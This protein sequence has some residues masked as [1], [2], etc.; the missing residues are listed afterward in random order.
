MKANIKLALVGGIVLVL[1]VILVALKFSSEGGAEDPAAEVA[2]ETVGAKV[3][4][5]QSPQSRRVPTDEDGFVEDSK[6]S[7]GELEAREAAREVILEKMHFAATSYDAAEL[8]VIRP[9]L[10][11]PDPELRAAAVDAMLLLGDSSAGWMLREA[12]KRLGSV[13]E[14]KV[15]NEA[16][17]YIEM[18]PANLTKIGEMM[19]KREEERVEKKSTPS[20]GEGAR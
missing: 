6:L 18:P 20:G 17:E 7:A 15:M 2:R 14:Q 19:K 10:E 11:S 9:Y 8:P 4:P 12:A 16:A 5:R 3:P 13:E 1:A